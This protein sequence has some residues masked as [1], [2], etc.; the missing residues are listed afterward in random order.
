MGVLNAAQGQKIAALTDNEVRQIRELYMEIL[1]T[2]DLSR[3]PLDT[4]MQILKPE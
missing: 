2:N 3:V 4:L 1:E